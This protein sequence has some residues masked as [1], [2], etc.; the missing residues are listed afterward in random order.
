MAARRVTQSSVNW[1]AL[2]ERVPQAQRPSFIAFKSKSDKYMRSVQANPE[3]APKIEWAR[4]KSAIPVPGLVDTFQKQYESIKVP[5]PEDTFTAEVEKQEQEVKREVQEF[6]RASEERIAKHQKEIAHLKSLIPFD[7]MT[8]E[9]FRDA[10]PDQ[11]LDAINKPTFWPH[12][13]EEQLDYKPKDGHAAG[14]H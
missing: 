7:Q 14:G 1:A 11:A 8:M 10:Y 5:Y 2:S 13:P 3:H 9:D 4:Y 6:I 12:N